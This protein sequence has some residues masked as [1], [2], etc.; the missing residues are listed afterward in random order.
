MR[1]RT[2]LQSNSEARNR[3]GHPDRCLT[4]RLGS[5]FSRE[6]NLRSMVYRGKYLPRQCVGITASF[7]GVICFS[8]DACLIADGQHDNY[9]LRKQIWRHTFAASTSAFD[10][11]PGV[12][13]ATPY[14]I[15]SRIHT[16]EGEHYCRFPIP[17]VEPS[18]STNGSFARGYSTGPFCTLRYNPKWIYSPHV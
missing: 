13:N 14:N 3:S 12:L 1:H 9:P 16:R 5:F 6:D 2:E 17:P 4:D 8:Q 10:T 18:T 15:D 7:F 11:A